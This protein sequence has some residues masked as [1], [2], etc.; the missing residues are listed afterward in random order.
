MHPE[1]GT[2]SP[3]PLLSNVEALH[4]GIGALGLGNVEFM[5]ETNVEMV[6]DESFLP[7]AEQWQTAE[8][9]RRYE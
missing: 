5:L 1:R 2:G 6:A 9:I 4:G 3:L 7:D 8:A